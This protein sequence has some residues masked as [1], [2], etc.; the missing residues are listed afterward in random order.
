MCVSCVSELRCGAVR[1]PCPETQTHAYA[2][3]RLRIAG[4]TRPLFSDEALDLIY[5]YS[6]G[7]PRIINLLREHTL[8]VAYVEQV[9]QV[10]RSDCGRELQ[11]SLNWRPNHF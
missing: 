7:I 2:A 10:S 11:R 1:R 9:P 4:A 6:H 3:E 8:I 5:R